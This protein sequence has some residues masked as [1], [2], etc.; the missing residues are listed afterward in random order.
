MFIVSLCAVVFILTAYNGISQRTETITVNSPSL[1][2]VEE[3][4]NN[5]LVA[6]SLQCPCQQISSTY[7]NFITLTPSYHQL[8]SSVYVTS[9][10]IDG[11]KVTANAIVADFLYYADFRAYFQFF[12][13]LQSVCT[14]ATS[15][16]SNALNDFGNLRLITASFLTRQAFENQM[17]SSAAFLKESTI[18]DL[19]SL[20]HLLS[21]TTQVNQYLSGNIGNFNI[22]WSINSTD[23]N[24]TLYP[25]L[26]PRISI[27][28]NNGTRSCFCM[29][30]TSCRIPI[31]IFSGYTISTLV[32]AIPGLY[33]GCSSDLSLY[34]STLEC[35]YDNS[36][37][38]AEIDNVSGTNFYSTFTRLNSNLSSRFLPNS[39][40]GA[41]LENLFIES[42]TMNIS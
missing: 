8:C 10:W 17:N 9:Q 28:I 32:Y 33:M 16:L 21:N 13:M 31:G 35:F 20:M 2:I 40:I 25:K 27:F 42:W 30:D 23:S 29:N 14:L 19:L 1:E 34:V 15:T 7:Q 41:L 36:N 5:P 11:M 38:L 26:I 37:C 6:L 22:K 39:T 12:N 4:Q 24:N 3:W 18:N